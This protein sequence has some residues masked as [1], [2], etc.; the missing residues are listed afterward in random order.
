MTVKELIEELS[1]YEDNIPVWNG[2]S[3]SEVVTV[4]PGALNYLY[5]IPEDRIIVII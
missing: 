1:K 4:N 3:N 2:Q 5:D